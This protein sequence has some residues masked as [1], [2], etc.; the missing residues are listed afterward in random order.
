MLDILCYD[1]ALTAGLTGAGTYLVLGI[2]S[3]TS[4]KIAGI[5]FVA[6]IASKYVMNHHY[7]GLLG[8]NK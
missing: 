7:F 3:N 6:G 2:P 1:C 8:S 4:M 5:D